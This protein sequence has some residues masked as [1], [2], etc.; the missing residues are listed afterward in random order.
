MSDMSDTVYMSD[1]GHL[2]IEGGGCVRVL[3]VKF[4]RMKILETSS[5]AHVAGQVYPYRL[6]HNGQ[7]RTLS[8]PTTGLSPV[9]P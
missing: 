2:K 8:V 4:V 7:T 3:C 9:C 6:G 5:I 1:R